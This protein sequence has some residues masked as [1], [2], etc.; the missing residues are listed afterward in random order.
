[1]S[2]LSFRVKNLAT[3]LKE[4][5]T[6]KAKG[7]WY[8]KRN[9]SGTFKLPT[10]ILLGINSTDELD[11]MPED[12]ALSK[13]N[14][15]FGALST[16]FARPC[17][18]RP[19]H[20][21]VE[22]EPVTSLTEAKKIYEKALAVDPNA[23]LLIMPFLE[24]ETSAIYVPESGSLVIGP[25]H[26]GAT[27]GRE[28]VALSVISTKMAKALRDGAGIAKGEHVY[29]EL[30]SVMA[31]VAGTYVVQARS[32]PPIPKGTQEYIP[33]KTKIE[34]IIEPTDDLLAWQALCTAIAGSTGVVAW[35]PG[36]SLACHA[37]IHCRANKLPYLTRMQRPDL[38]DVIEPE[39]ATVQPFDMLEFHRGVRLSETADKVGGLTLAIG[40]LHNVLALEYS[41]Y[42]S[43]LLGYAVGW[44]FRGAAIACLG[45]SRHYKGPKKTAID[46]DR[47]AVYRGAEEKDNAEL[48]KR[49]A[50]FSYKFNHTSWSS[51]YGG[52][53]WYSALVQAVKLWNYISVGR[54]DQALV[55]AN[56]ILTMAHNG[57][58]LYNK[59]ITESVMTTA[60][61]TP[62][63]HL[64]NNI[65]PLYT[66]LT[67]CTKH[68]PILS[69]TVRSSSKWKVDAH[70]AATGVVEMVVKDL[71][72]K[73][74]NWT[75]TEQKVM[76]DTFEHV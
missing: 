31:P 19:Q 34:H 39:Q 42:Y 69:R 12:V 4:P 3:T 13:W 26:N 21:F 37:A 60:A 17:P 43:R 14:S 30:V 29:M 75:P 68:P 15:V 48:C 52:W 50:S 53:K 71:V 22:S 67:D 36:G 1:M 64:A 11:G 44:V 72:W 47:S 54:H 57:G 16:A 18:E 9:P 45:E 35:Q 32:G 20:G 59:F 38:G 49:L 28:S 66:L 25:K 5:H 6:Q 62:A 76:E 2:E 61:T 56:A 51:G 63:E 55:E 73:M 40:I 70:W 46:A 27:S 65:T 7:V 23:E 10:K 41:E 33:H 8:L 74:I 58:W 24:A